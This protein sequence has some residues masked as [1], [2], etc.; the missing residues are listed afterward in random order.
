MKKGKINV[1]KQ[2]G[3]HEA[4]PTSEESQHETRGETQRKRDEGAIFTTETNRNRIFTNSF[5]NGGT[6]GRKKETTVM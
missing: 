2:E 4:L 3:W 1:G 6:T 5:Y